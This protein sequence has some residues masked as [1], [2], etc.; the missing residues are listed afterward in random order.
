MVCW[1]LDV[2]SKTQKLR[3]VDGKYVC[4]LRHMAA[5]GW[6]ETTCWL[7]VVWNIFFT[8]APESWGEM[9]QFDFRISFKTKYG[10]MFRFKHAASG[11][12]RRNHRK[13][14]QKLPFFR[15]S[16]FYMA[17]L[18]FPTE[19][20]YGT[21]LSCLFLTVFVPVRDILFELRLPILPEN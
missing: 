7:V 17:N 15:I 10:R 6:L 5:N 14:L 4:A 8:V 21:C 2:G 3:S 13:R 11:K 1:L 12:K 16:K 9:I 18:F 19:R 20:F